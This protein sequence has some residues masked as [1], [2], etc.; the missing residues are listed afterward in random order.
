MHTKNRLCTNIRLLREE[1][2]EEMIVVVENK[3]HKLL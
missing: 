1:E 2:E 3:E